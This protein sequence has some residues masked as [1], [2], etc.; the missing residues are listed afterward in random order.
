VFKRN[1]K[2]ERERERERERGLYRY[3]PHFLSDVTAILLHTREE[4]IAA[5]GREIEIPYV[6][7]K[8]GKSQ[9]E[10]TRRN[11]WGSDFGRSFFDIQLRFR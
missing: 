5:E 7:T 11:R 10:K 3:F 4:K 1:E 8:G 6:Y 2:R 9:R